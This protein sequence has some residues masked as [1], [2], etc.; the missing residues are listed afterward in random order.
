[1]D[2]LA[3]VAVIG[4]L[5]LLVEWEVSV[6]ALVSDSVPVFTRLVWTL[7]PACD[8]LLIALVVR[9]AMTR[10]PISPRWSG[11][12]WVPGEAAVA[13]AGRGGH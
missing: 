11:G 4:V 9:V 12:R 2:G 1:L 13:I 10:L 6:G 3:D 5:V 8:A 7:Y